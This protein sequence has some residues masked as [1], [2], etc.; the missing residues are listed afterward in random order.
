MAHRR[1][2]GRIGMESRHVHA[3]GDGDRCGR[4][5]AEGV[6]SHAQVLAACRHGAGLRERPSRNAPDR[7]VPLC[8]VHVR[9]VQADHERQF[10]RCGSRHRAARHDP[11]AVHERRADPLRHR[12]RGT[13]AG[14]QRQRRCHQRRA[15]HR[16]VGTQGAGVAEDVERRHRRVPEQMERDA[17]LARRARPA[18]MPRQHHVDVVATRGHAVR[19]RLHERPDRVAREPGV[20]GCHHHDAVACAH[21][22]LRP[23]D[24]RRSRQG[25]RHDSSSTL[26][27]N[28]D[29]PSRRSTKTIG[30]SPTRAPRRCASKSISTRNA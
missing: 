21:E 14:G 4:I 22:G 16:D 23:S 27:D 25:V 26:P 5:G 9:A 6:R 18:R 1:A 24:L 12:A 10:T 15:A 29:T 30:T 17:A 13:P 8:E 28:F 11:V 2:R 3:V 7:A 19:D 20:R